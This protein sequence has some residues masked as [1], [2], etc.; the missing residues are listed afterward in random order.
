MSGLKAT[1]LGLAVYQGL[2]EIDDQR[3]LTRPYSGW[4]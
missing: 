2:V 3:F 4:A 1:T